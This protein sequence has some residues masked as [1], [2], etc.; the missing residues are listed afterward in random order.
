MHRSARQRNKMKVRKSLSDKLKNKIKKVARSVRGE[1]HSANQK[2]VFSASLPC[3]FSPPLTPSSVMTR[4]AGYD[5][6][7]HDKEYLR[8]ASLSVQRSRVA[9][10]SMPWRNSELTLHLSI[11][12]DVVHLGQSFSLQV[13]GPSRWLKPANLWPCVLIFGREPCC[14]ARFN[15]L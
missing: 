8:S 13:H 7:R 10:A 11:E 9:R 15:V 14:S 6:S 4:S 5:A 3:I 12:I 2:A 1:G